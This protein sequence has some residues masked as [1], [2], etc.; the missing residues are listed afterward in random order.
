MR[1]IAVLLACLLASAVLVLFLVPARASAPTAAGL[2]EGTA[3]GVAANAGVQLV[4]HS[5][6]YTARFLRIASGAKNATTSPA[7]LHE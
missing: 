2:H 6:G 4:R 3:S 7:S 5:G 1:R